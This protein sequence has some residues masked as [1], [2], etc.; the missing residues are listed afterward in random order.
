MQGR[1]RGSARA[2]AYQA[3]KPG[4][5]K[6]VLDSYGRMRGEADLV[7][8]EGAGSASEVNLRAGDI[9]NMGF[10]RAADVPVV[11]IGD[12]DRGGVIA[13]LVGTHA[14]L[15]PADAAMVVGFVV[16]RMRGDPTLFDDGM[17]FV[18]AR[19]GWRA[20]GLVPH[21]EP[22][23]LLPAE[24]AADLRAVAT[25]P[26]AGV[27][28]VVPLLPMI[29]NFDDLDPLAQE[30]D[31]D[32]VLVRPGDALPV[33]DLVLL[34]GSKSTIAD[35]AA[36][37]AAGWAGD[38]VAHR[39]RGGR[40][41]GVC[42]G[43]QMLGRVVADPD[44]VEGP[45]G[46]VAG[47][48][49]LEVETVLSGEK[50]LEAV[51]GEGFTGY[52]MHMGVTT[53][54]DTARPMLRLADGRADGARSADGLVAG[55]YVHGLFGHDGQRAAWLAMLGAAPSGHRHEAAVEAT[56]DGLAAHLEAHMD[57]DRLLRLAR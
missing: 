10:A 31:V 42:G 57:L 37:R 24:D 22:A 15:D 16:N 45:A 19:T 1:V 14:V 52:A 33:C 56:L 23:A 5:M 26:G 4:L 20:L 34:P 6:D 54:A 11:V 9:A 41:L 36:F 21:F 35:L 39:R 50:R 29:A 28:I 53:G 32:L 25:R 27:R 17:A 3:M 8:V 51:S 48:G 13:S 43:Y 55:T 49:M 38:L 12:I 2:R 18:T 44:G 30:A 40:V 47:L 46:A 7:L